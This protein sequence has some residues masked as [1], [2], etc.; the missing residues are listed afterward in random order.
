MSE[1]RKLLDDNVSLPL[2]PETGKVLGLRRGATYAAARS[3][4]IKTL[5]FGRL[6]KVPTAWLR[7][8][9]D[10]VEPAVNTPEQRRGPK[11]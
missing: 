11:D 6:L 10:I 8:K 2:W 7:Q 5:R 1:V 9:L 4:E 3:G